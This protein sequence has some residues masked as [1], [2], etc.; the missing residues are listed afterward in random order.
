MHL[1]LHHSKKKSSMQCRGIGVGGLVVEWVGRGLRFGEKR[2]GGWKGK[3][4]WL[5]RGYEV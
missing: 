3:R 4:G 2:K 1:R 5:D